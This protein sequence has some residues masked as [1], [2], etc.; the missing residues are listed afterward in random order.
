M[1]PRL[2]LSLL[3]LSVSLT[4]A[5][6]QKSNKDGAS[7]AERTALEQEKKNLNDQK[8][9]MENDKRNMEA[10]RA[11]LEAEQKKLEEDKKN[12]PPAIPGETP[13]TP[14]A[15]TYSCAVDRPYNAG[16]L[17][18]I[19][20]NLPLPGSNNQQREVGCNERL[21]GGDQQRQQQACTAGNLPQMGRNT[22]W[23]VGGCPTK[24]F[25]QTKVGGCRKTEGQNTIDTWWWYTP[26]AIANIQQKCQKEGRT[27]VSP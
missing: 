19:I 26:Y 22:Q 10:E 7:D 4:F 21:N 17:G 25:N 9:Q 24:V 8:T 6:K 1:K 15:N 23:I 27:Y 5:C 16:G 13:T 20:P 14:A 12:N 2:V 11:K 18:G 3:V